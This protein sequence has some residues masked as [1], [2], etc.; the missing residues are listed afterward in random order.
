MP[1]KISQ[2]HAGA[3]EKPGWN[4]GGGEPGVILNVSGRPIQ[5]RKTNFFKPS[6]G[7]TK[8][9]EGGKN[10]TLWQT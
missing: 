1:R 4:E 5:I 7:A 3:E 9:S 8:S 6:A 2:E 10:L